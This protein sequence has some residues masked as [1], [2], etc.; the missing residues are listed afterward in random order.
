MPYDRYIVSA[1]EASPDLIYET[2]LAPPVERIE[3]AYSL[4]EIRYS[5]DVRNLMPRVDSTPSTFDT[6]SWKSP[7]I[8]SVGRR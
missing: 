5:P 8:N 3:R 7:P 1:D 2:M 4:D 6:G